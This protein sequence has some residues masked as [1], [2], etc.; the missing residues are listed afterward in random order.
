VVHLE[1][2]E[3]K[4]SPTI[5]FH[6]FSHTCTPLLPSKGAHPKFVRELPA[7]LTLNYASSES[8]RYPSR[9]GGS[10]AISRQNSR[11]LSS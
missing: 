3:R 6:H 11:A 5:S 10:R 4:A 2:E 1:V 7:Y 9:P 8:G